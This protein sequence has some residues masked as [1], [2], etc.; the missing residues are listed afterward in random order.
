[1]RA[2]IAAER[3]GIPSVSIVC[4]GFVGQAAATSRGHG[5]D[6]LPL[7]VISGHVDAVGWDELRTEFVSATVA[8]V[9]TGLT[10]E[11]DPVAD[12]DGPEPSPLDIVARGDH[13][14]IQDL[15]IGRGW[16]D[17]LPFVPP[18]RAR[19]EAMIGATGHDPWR[20]L[21]V[22]ATSGRDMTVWSVAVNAVMAGCRPEHFPVG[23]AVAAAGQRGRRAEA[24]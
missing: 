18:T 5:F 8:Q 13:D 24:T 6:D 12:A 9:V 4:E 20:I 16:S 2:A 19:V 17:G 7:A 10:R 1:M 21:G 14:T 22:T 3:A 23:M 15:F 11:A